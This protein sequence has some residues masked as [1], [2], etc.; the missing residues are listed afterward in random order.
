MLKVMGIVLLLTHWDQMVDNSFDQEEFHR[1]KKARS[2]YNDQD[3]SE[4]LSFVRETMYM[5]CMILDEE[6]IV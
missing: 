3:S 6:K 5:I 2:L 4:Y 1:H